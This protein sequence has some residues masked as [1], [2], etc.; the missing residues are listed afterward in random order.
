[1][2]QH[3]FLFQI[4]PVQTFIAASRRTQDLYVG[5]RLLSEIALAGVKAAENAGGELVFPVKGKD[6]SDYPKSVSHIFACTVTTDRPEAFGQGVE[7]ALRGHWQGIAAKVRSHLQ[8]YGA[9]P[10]WTA[11]FDAQVARWLEVY[12]VAVAVEGDH[13]AAYDKARKAMSARKNLRH[14]PQMQDEKGRKCTLT[15]AM[16]ALEI[17]WESLSRRSGGVQVRPNEALGAIAAIKRFAQDAKV[18][19]EE[20][21]TFSDLDEIAGGESSDDEPRYVAALH[22]DGDQMGKRLSS[23]KSKAEHQQFSQTLADFADKTVP[24][25][26]GKYK[27]G[28]L[29]Y[30]GGDDVLALLPIQSALGCANELQSEFRQA[31]GSLTM[32]AGIAIA[33]SNYPFDLML[34]AAREAEK[35]AKQRYGRNAVCVVEVHGGQV[36]EAGMKWDDM[37]PVFQLQGYFYLKRVSKGLGYDLRQLAHDMGGGDV[38]AEARLLET[39]RLLKRRINEKVDSVKRAEIVKLADELSEIAEKTDGGGERGWT[40]VANWAILAR[41]LEGKE[42]S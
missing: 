37:K 3:L 39:R 35:K 22:M 16:A 10:N 18:F 42:G 12:W 1:M 40:A 26:I 23:L 13:G 30:A 20:L 7:A 33:P 38:P 34:D 27:P 17:D 32:S 28:V 14:F 21:Q 2:T 29:I 11:R 8:P 5:S 15:G 4:G 25:I 9:S 31:S 6:K 19:N 24:K 36:R 41:F